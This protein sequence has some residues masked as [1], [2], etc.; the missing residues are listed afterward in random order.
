MGTSCRV[1]HKALVVCNTW[2]KACV[3]RDNSRHT[4]SAPDGRTKNQIDYIMMNKRYWN[5][6]KNAKARPGA[7]CGSDNNPVVMNIKTKLKR[8]KKSR[9]IRKKW[10]VSNLDQEII[11]EK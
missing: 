10:N 7:D 6:I 5:S 1:M 11:K 8:V 2:F 9:S 3:Q 4:W